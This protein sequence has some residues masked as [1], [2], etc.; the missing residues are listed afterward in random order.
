[1]SLLTWFFFIAKFAGVWLALRKYDVRG[2][3]CA[4][5]WWWTSVV[6]LQVGLGVVERC[7]HHLELRET[8]A[9]LKAEPYS[10]RQSRQE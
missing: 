3:R 5:R 4:W 7:G 6:G 1:M 9:N 8:R 10:K 2:L